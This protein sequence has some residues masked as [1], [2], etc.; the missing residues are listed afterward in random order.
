MKTLN[1]IFLAVVILFLHTEKSHSQLSGAYT[2]GI[3]G[4]YNTISAAAK[5]LIS[6]GMNGPVTFN[7]MPGIYCES[8]TIDSI[9]GSSISST[10]IFQSQTGNP[11]DVIWKDSTDILQTFVILN[12]ADNIVF[13]NM[14]FINS[15]SFESQYIFY[16]NLNC[17]NV[18]I[19]NNR[20]TSDGFLNSYG[21][22]CSNTSSTK[23][24]MI[25][26][27]TIN[28]LTI[29]E[30]TGPFISV[31]TSIINNVLNTLSG[32]KLRHHESVT[33]DRNVIEAHD[34]FLSIAPVA[35]S[36]QNCTKN[37]RIC[38]NRIASIGEPR[39]RPGSGITLNECLW[40]SSLIA[41]NF[42]YY[43]GVHGLSVSNCTNVKIYFNTIQ[44]LSIVSDNIRDPNII[45][46]NNSY[47]EVKNNIMG[48][49]AT[50]YVSNNNTNIS[51]DFN[52]F[53]P[54]YPFANVFMLYH[55]QTGYSEIEQFRTA[56][57]NDFHS[58][59]K[60]VYF[61][62]NVDLHLSGVSIG[63]TSLRGIPIEGISDDIDGNLRNTSRPYIGAD[64]AE[65][66][67]PVELNSFVFAVSSDNVILNWV[68]AYEINNKG[69]SIERANA[70]NNSDDQWIATGFVNGIGS[71]NEATDYSFTDKNLEPGRYKY[72]L[73]Q[74]DF[75]GNFEFHNLE[76]E[77]VINIPYEYSL[78]QNFPNPFNPTTVIKY[79][80]TKNVR[81]SLIVYD[82]SGKEVAT[83][84]NKILN[85]G[86]YEV[87]FDASNLP[88]G[89]YFYAMK[90]DGELVASKRMTLVK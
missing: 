46:S 76:H 36:L 49:R 77:V 82:V 60:E 68:T 23:Q 47:C 24:L 63:D 31:N 20:M 39:F 17:D 11:E 5:D 81:L 51:S 56:S 38:K 83:I 8:V 9:P 87:Q 12:G 37:L 13:K 73:K 62:S 64:E 43:T 75:N 3:G 42:I 71:T 55:N 74:I 88:S 4:N 84:V 48:G 21:I 33:I 45:I 59:V 65:S 27:N 66:P 72:R 35:I 58:L 52:L 41:N 30:S 78:L 34:T 70:E 54:I 32:I 79:E 26:D 1:I 86:R 89:V 25:K 85:A 15:F 90:I 28:S 44:I 18:Q 29:M 16:L 10:V 61:V 69:F 53:Y 6:S 50:D 14:T 67:L 2:I 40:D 22:Y 7:I 19:V 57:N 80:L